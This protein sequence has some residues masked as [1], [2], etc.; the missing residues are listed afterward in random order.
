MMYS[1]N[2]FLMSILAAPI[3]HH[4]K[5]PTDWPERVSQ[6][7]HQFF[8]P[9][10]KSIASQAQE[11]RRFLSLGSWGLYEE[12]LGSPLFS[13]RDEDTTELPTIAITDV[14]DTILSSVMMVK[15]TSTVCAKRGHK[16]AR[17][18]WIS[19]LTQLGI[20]IPEDIILL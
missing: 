17:L 18:S 19:L 8:R 4:V 2:L 6:I 20:G 13:G 15:V 7:S 11:R 10:P 9:L 12:A 3:L 5:D 1:R 14:V 16:Q